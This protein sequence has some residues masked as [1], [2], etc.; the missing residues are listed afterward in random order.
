MIDRPFAH[1]CRMLILVAPIQLNFQFNA[2]VQRPEVLLG[3]KQVLF[4]CRVNLLLFW[5]FTVRGWGGEAFCLTCNYMVLS[6]LLNQQEKP[7]HIMADS[8]SKLNSDISRT[9]TA[10]SIFQGATQYLLERG[11]AEKSVSQF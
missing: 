10:L 3:V 5:S 11:T 9:V 2:Y 7:Q 6:T 1:L 8:C 4:P